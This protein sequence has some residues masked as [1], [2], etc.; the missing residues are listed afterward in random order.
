MYAAFI[1]FEMLHLDPLIVLLPIAAAFFGIGYLLQRTLINPF[2]GRAEHEQFI[3]LVGLATVIVNG[4]LLV[5]GPDARPINLSYSFDSYA[6]GPMFLDKV[7]V[8]AALARRLRSPPRC[9][10]SSATHAPAPRSAP[11]PTI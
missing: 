6:I 10:C 7:R 3:L 8:F 1:L 4:L 11:A 9:C 5:F 2:V